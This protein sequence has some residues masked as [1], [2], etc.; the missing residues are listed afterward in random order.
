MQF[1]TPL[2]KAILIKRY[3]RFLADVTLEDGTIVTA[4][5]PNTGSMHGF[6]DPGSI[7][8]LSSSN[9]PKRKLKYT[10]EL[11][12]EKH[13]G[14]LIGINT[15]LPNKL[16]LEALNLNKIKELNNFKEIRREVPY[17]ANSRI[18]FLISDLSGKSCYVEVKNVHL[19]RSKGLAEFPDSVTSRGKKH[20]LELTKI[21]ERGDI[22]YMLYLVQRNDCT[23]LKLACD[24]DIDYCEAFNKATKAGVKVLCFGCQMSLKQIYLSKKIKFEV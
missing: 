24:I 17:G 9:N 16:V 7:I 14:N 13:S 4:H 15:S 20:L 19:S 12:E 22:A 18:D 1:K 21:A 3:K 6:S 8:W 2:I 5:C 10:W 11:Y 23:K